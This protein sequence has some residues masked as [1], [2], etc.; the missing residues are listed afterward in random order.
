MTGAAVRKREL[1]ISS[2]IHRRNGAQLCRDAELAGRISPS[3][4]SRLRGW[5][6]A[7]NVGKRKKWA[8]EECAPQPSWADLPDEADFSAKSIDRPLSQY[9]DVLVVG[10]NGAAGPSGGEARI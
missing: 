7:G 3:Q 4:V 2:G 1:E 10:G 5:N 9:W 8:S 6:M